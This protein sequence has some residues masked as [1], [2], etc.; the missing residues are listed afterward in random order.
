MT[1]ASKP[2]ISFL[3]RIFLRLGSSSSCCEAFTTYCNIYIDTN[4]TSSLFKY[5]IVFTLYCLCQHNFFNSVVICYVH[6][7][8][9]CYCHVYIHTPFPQCFSQLAIFSLTLG[10]TK[11]LFKKSNYLRQK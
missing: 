8:N 11:K 10:V 7:T 1:I 5:T 3:W 2:H 9:V 6:G 4:V